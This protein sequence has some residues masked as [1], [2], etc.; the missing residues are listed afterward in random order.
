MKETNEKNIYWTKNV[1]KNLISSVEMSIGGISC[2]KQVYCKEC[3]EFHK[4]DK[5]CC[6]ICKN[7]HEK[8]MSCIVSLM[9]NDIKKKENINI[10]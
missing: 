3:D 9:L 2:G 10:I 5:I 4:G 7:C 8:D 6:K 1:G